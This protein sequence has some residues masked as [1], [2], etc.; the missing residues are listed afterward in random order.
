MKAILASIALC[1]IFVAYASAHVT[2]VGARPPGINAADY[3][4][5]NSME[6]CGNGTYDAS[7]AINVTSGDIFPITW[8][9]YVNHNMPPAVAGSVNFYWGVSGNAVIDPVP[10]TT[11]PDNTYYT[12]YFV[13]PDVFDVATL[14]VLLSDSHL[15]ILS[16]DV[17]VVRILLF[18][19]N[20][21]PSR[22]SLFFNQVVYDTAGAADNY[23]QCVD[24]FITIA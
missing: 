20:H 19:S 10:V 13:V 14:Q 22:L 7:R 5:S 23:F 16:I 8:A 2:V 3:I 17:H 6:P 12:T 9:L 1:L 11:Q 15:H 21:L 4:K 24:F 18:D